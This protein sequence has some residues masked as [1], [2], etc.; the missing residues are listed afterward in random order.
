MAIHPPTRDQVLIELQL[1]TEEWLTTAKPEQIL[2]RLGLLH[3]MLN[4]DLASIKC[5]KWEKPDGPAHKC[6]SCDDFVLAWETVAN[7]SRPE[8]KYIR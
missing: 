7:T 4:E 2:E 6:S 5:G 3:G 8:L 1:Q